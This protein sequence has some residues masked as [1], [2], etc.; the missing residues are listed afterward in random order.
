M[1]IMGGKNTKSMSPME[2]IIPIDKTLQ[3]DIVLICKSCKQLLNTNKF[4]SVISMCK[5][6]NNER[7]F[8]FVMT[9]NKLEECFVAPQMAFAQIYQLN[10]VEVNM[11]FKVVLL[12]F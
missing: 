7:K 3:L 11:T 12:M 5:H 9:L 1:Q 2:S 4:N 6:I 10:M 8:S